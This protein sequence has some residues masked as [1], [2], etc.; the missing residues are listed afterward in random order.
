M[1]TIVQ[2]IVDDM[3]EEEFVA[4]IRAIKKRFNKEAGVKAASLVDSKESLA[5]MQTI[6]REGTIA[7]IRQI[8]KETKE[9][10]VTCKMTVDILEEIHNVLLPLEFRNVERTVS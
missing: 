1:D 2:A 5:W 7:A 8:R 3:D 4:Y 6:A 10:L 9:P